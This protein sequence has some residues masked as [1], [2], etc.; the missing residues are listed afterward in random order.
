MDETK[1]RAQTLQETFSVHKRRNQNFTTHLSLTLRPP[2][3]SSSRVVSRVV[4][5]TVRSEIS[6]SPMMRFRL[7]RGGGRSF[8]RHG[9]RGCA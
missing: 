1:A 9:R 8:E 7:K 6:S 2:W 3:S 5:F 4:I